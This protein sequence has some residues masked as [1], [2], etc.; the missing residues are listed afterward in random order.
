MTLDNKKSQVTIFIVLA[1]VIIA[2][3][4]IFFLVRQRY[5]SG[6]QTSIEIDSRIMPVYESVS[7]CLEQKAL[8]G[9]ELIRLQGGYVTLPADV[10]RVKVETDSG[11]KQVPLWISESSI[12]IPSLAFIETELEDYLKMQIPSCINLNLLEQRG[13]N[14]SQGA[15]EPSVRLSDT[16]SI[17]IHWP[18]YILYHGDSYKLEDFRYN[19]NLNFKEIYEIASSLAL[20]ELGYNYLEYHALS[21]ISLFSY[22]G[23]DKRVYDLPPRS[24]TDSNLDCNFAVWNQQEVASSLK[25]IFS[26]SYPYLK[27]ENTN[28]EPFEGDDDMSQGVYDSFVYDYFPERHENIQVDFSYSPDNTLELSLTPSSL[29]PERISTSTV[30]F[31]PRFCTFNYEFSYTLSAPIITKIT[32]LNSRN[33]RD[34]AL[35]ETGFEFYFPMK[36]SICNDYPRE[37]GQELEYE[38]DY[39]AIEN[40]TGVKFYDCNS[41]DKSQAITVKD[42]AGNSLSGV[43]ITHFCEGFANNCWLGRTQSSSS[44]FN[45]PQ[46]ANSS[47]ELVK[48]GYGTL[49]SSLSSG[50]TL[51][52]LK[53]YSVEIKLVKADKFAE[54]YLLT[55]GY[56]ADA[57]GKTPGTWLS[58]AVY[59]P[60]S[61]DSIM[62][63]LGGVNGQAITYPSV[64]TIALAPGNY[65]LTGVVN[66]E[67][68]IKPSI[69]NGVTVSFN[70]DDQSSPYTG[71]WL[72]GASSYNLELAPADLSGKTTATF[73]I[74]VEKLSSE[75]LSVSSFDDALL[76]D[77]SILGKINADSNCNGMLVEHNIAIN[78][79]D[80]IKVIKP[81]FT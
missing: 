1:V 81:K 71:N 67:V 11:E 56:T 29:A 14:I 32:S 6:S 65:E 69:Y 57:C 72:M 8:S 46:C 40:S 30:P 4:V 63:S 79:S 34:S 44:I 25:T 7:S 64:N 33:I 43:D 21:L 35:A 47:I 5:I 48:P 23:G 19:L 55:N 3:V 58:Y 53:N 13:F 70:Q 61:K 39:S 62:L 27:M 28:F 42:E 20:Y 68:T 9:L 2:A 52:S 15:I 17:N 31:A 22:S 12:S 50:Y 80:Y 10:S 24:F 51:H 18:T 41:I 75:D 74:L 66:S 49:K 37:C 78:A 16:A 60:K 77:S 45:I 59:E 26:G 54:G 73:Y 76:H 36:L 38:L